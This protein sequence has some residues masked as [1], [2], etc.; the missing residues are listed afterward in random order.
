MRFINKM[1]M[2]VLATSAILCSGCDRESTPPATATSMDVTYSTIDGS[3]ELIAWNGE[4]LA[5][6][7]YCYTEFERSERHFEM[8]SNFGSM[9]ADKRSGSFDIEQNEYGEF[10]LT[11]IY[12]NGIGDWTDSYT[13][14]MS[15]SGSEMQWKAAS[16]NNVYTYSKIDDIPELN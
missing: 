12:D 1:I 15:Q 10:I 6:G 3:W 13:V 9:Y 5:E 7:T 4:A 11:G 14:T 8:W 16:T 2:A